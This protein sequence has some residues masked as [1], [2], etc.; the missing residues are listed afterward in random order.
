[1]RR[2]TI[3]LEAISGA[4]YIV[5]EDTMSFT[6]ADENTPSIELPVRLLPR[7]IGLS[8]HLAGRIA[9]LDAEF[10]AAL[11]LDKWNVSVAQ[12]GSVL[13]EVELP[14]GAPLTFAFSVEKANE[15]GLLLLRRKSGGNPQ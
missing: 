15:L 14:G 2:K 11:C 7:L 10:S 8:L 3:R 4:E 12:D 13:M 9:R 6:T 1:M 5:S